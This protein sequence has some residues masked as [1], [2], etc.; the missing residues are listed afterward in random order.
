MYQTLKLVIL[1]LLS[2]MI[3][4]ILMNIINDHGIKFVENFQKLWDKTSM[5]TLPQI[6]VTFSFTGNDFNIDNVTQQMNIV[7]TE[8]RKKKDFP[9]NEF[10]YTCWSLY[11][12]KE[13]CKAV[14]LQFE[15]IMKLL[16]GKEEFVKQICN[17]NNINAE[18]GFDL[19]VD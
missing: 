16:I 18:V 19:Y 11:T 6:R 8:I 10:A 2:M 3:I 5:E 14:S 13:S 17:D 12:E 4:K 9:I 1:I 15:K 7:P